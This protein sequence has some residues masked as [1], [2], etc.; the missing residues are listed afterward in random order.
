MSR[1]FAMVAVRMHAAVLSAVANVPPLSIHYA[2]KGK[3]FMSDIGLSDYTLAAEDV[4]CDILVRLFN[5]LI[6]NYGDIK[7]VLARNVRASSKGLL[8]SVSRIRELLGLGSLDEATAAEFFDSIDRR[9]DKH[10]GL[11][12]VKQQNTLAS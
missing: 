11:D 6:G 1:M 12:A 4:G 7:S 10:L 8:A 5:R 9:S 3:S 2:S